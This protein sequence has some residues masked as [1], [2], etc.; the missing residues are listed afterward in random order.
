MCV[1]QTSSPACDCRPLAPTFSPSFSLSFTPSPHSFSLP[2]SRPP[3]AS[4]KADS[5]LV[6]GAAGCSCSDAVSGA[7]TPGAAAPAAPAALVVLPFSA[8]LLLLSFHRRLAVQGWNGFDGTI[9][10]VGSAEESD[11]TDRSVFPE[12]GVWSESEQ[13]RFLHLF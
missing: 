1:S 10:P 9:Q 12:E 3:G 2:L 6:E 8:A 11:E 4:H 13:S 5:V 7:V